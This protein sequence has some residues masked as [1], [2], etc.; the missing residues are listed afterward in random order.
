MSEVAKRAPTELPAAFGRYKLLKLLG[1]GGMGS[2]YLAHDNRL[3]RQVAL[4]IPRLETDNS[5]VL[6]RFIREAQAAAAPKPAPECRQPCPRNLQSRSANPD[7][8]VR[9]RSTPAIQ[10]AAQ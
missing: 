4:K 5:Q 2:V 7:C 6:A 10:S 9:I 8:P 1:K 3:D